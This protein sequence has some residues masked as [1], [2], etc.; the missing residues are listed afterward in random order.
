MVGHRHRL[1]KAA[2]WELWLSH[3]LIKSEPR[4]R[5]G[6]ER[7]RRRTI[8]TEKVVSGR[9]KETLARFTFLSELPPTRIAMLTRARG[10]RPSAAQVAPPIAA[11]RATR[12]RSK[13][14]TPI[15]S[16]GSQVTTVGRFAKR[17]SQFVGYGSRGIWVPMSR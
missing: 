13:W 1:A 17:L 10:Q 11:Q 2:A 14:A 4:F 16:Q 3:Q 8:R 12:T 9:P 15:V 6:R 7:D 5:A